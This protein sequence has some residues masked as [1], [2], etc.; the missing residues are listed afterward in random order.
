VATPQINAKMAS[1]K[2][3]RPAKAF[4]QVLA[5]TTNKVTCLWRTTSGHLAYHLWKWPVE[6]DLLFVAEPV[7]LEEES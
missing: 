3:L 4:A 5:D 7:R 6:G 1:D 2:S